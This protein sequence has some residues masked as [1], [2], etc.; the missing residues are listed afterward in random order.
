MITRTHE[1]TRSRIKPRNTPVL[2]SSTAEGGPNTR[3]E[4]RIEH[5][6]TEETEKRVSPPFSP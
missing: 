5:E 3:N 2:R 1:L 6:Q 4:D